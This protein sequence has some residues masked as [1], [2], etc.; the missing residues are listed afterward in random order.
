MGT[1]VPDVPNIAVNPAMLVFG[2]VEVNT[3]SDLPLQ[4][5]NTGFMTLNVDT[6]R[7]VDPHFTLV[8][9]P[10]NLAIAPGNS[11]LLTVRFM[12]TAVGQIN[13]SLTMVTNVPGTQNFSVALAGTGK[14]V[15]AFDPSPNQFDPKAGVWD[16]FVTLFGKNFDVGPVRIQFSGVDLPRGPVNVT[17]TRIVAKVP[18]ATGEGGPLAGPVHIIVTNDAGTATSDDLFTVIPT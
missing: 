9:A 3:Y 15:V 4:I 5:Q 6:F 18:A 8:N 11:A 13:A 1:G 17:A 16:S 7:I 2:P 14:I 10:P 12:P